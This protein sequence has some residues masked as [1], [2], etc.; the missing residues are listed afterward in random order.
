M[1]F[2]ILK[3]VKLPFAFAVYFIVNLML[4]FF[5][6][7]QQFSIASGQENFLR[8]LYNCLIDKLCFLMLLNPSWV[9]RYFKVPLT[10]CFGFRPMQ[11][12]PGNFACGIWNPT[13]D[14]MRNPSTTDKESGM[15]SVESRIQDCLGFPYIGRQFV[16]KRW[17]ANHMSRSKFSSYESWS[18][19]VLV[20]NVQTSWNFL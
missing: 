13:N 1:C 7:V 20:F 2:R 3:S 11:L 5:I 19:V 15:H 16:Q 4:Q 10:S 18:W 12:N 8:G 17:C 9:R 14:W 6:N